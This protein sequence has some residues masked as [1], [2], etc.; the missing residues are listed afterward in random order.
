MKFLAP[1]NTRNQNY[2]HILGLYG[3]Y[4]VYIPDTFDRVEWNLGTWH[5]SAAIGT[6]RTAL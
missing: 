1:L 6:S 4:W 3:Q 5:I 2:G